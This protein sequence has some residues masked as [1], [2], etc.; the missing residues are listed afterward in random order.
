MAPLTRILVAMSGGVDSSAVCLMLQDQ[1]YEVVGMTMR[2][3]DL[4]GQFVH[5]AGADGALPPCSHGRAGTEAEPDFI[6]NARQLAERLGI[7]HHV[8]DVREDFSHDVVDYFLDEYEAGR[9]PNPCVRCNRQFKF[10][11]LA[12]LADDLHCPWM[13]T[14]HYV[15]TEQRD[16]NTYLLMGADTRKDQSYFLWR[17]PQQILRRMRFPLG[18]LEKPMVRRYLEEKGF[19]LRARQSESMEV[20]FVEGDYRDF[21]RSQRPQC[22]SRTD[23]G[24]Y[25]D[26]GGKRLGTHH[27]VPFYTV[28]Q[29]K[30]LGIALG[31]PAYVLR[32][33]AQKNTIVLGTEQELLTRHLIV[34][35]PECVRREDLL[36]PD[37]SLSVRI[38]YH[39]R[40]VACTVR[41]LQDGRFL[42]T[43]S[44]DVSAVTPGQSAVF[45]IGNRMV[46]GAIIS[47]QKGIGGILASSGEEG[48]GKTD[49]SGSI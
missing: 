5:A 35:S 22:A 3:W 29:R 11:L 48:Q 23:G 9:T 32:L 40:P 41:D 20:C 44:Q 27:G 13:A 34:E 10:R 19:A 46:G 12:E 24:Y 37:G 36:A 47:T 18:E 43:T 2:V 4:P 8:V 6:V 16:G 49:V 26:S 31:F 7:E 25:V 30:G 21:L 42:V 1:G 38:R 14:G 45:Y 17:V 33:N 39:S 15:R 28:G